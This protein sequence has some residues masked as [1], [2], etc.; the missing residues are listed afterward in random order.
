MHDLLKPLWR[1]HGMTVIMVTHDLKE[2]FGLGTRLIAFDK[3]RHDPQAPGR[4]GARLTYDLDLPR[5]RAAP[6]AP[7]PR[8]NQD[9]HSGT[10]TL[11]LRPR[12]ST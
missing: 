8:A 7:V 5:R 12:H 6:V 1:Q 3:L 2:A 9:S 4:Y 11:P 10:S